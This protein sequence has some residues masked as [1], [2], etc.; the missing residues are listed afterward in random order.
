MN[1][2]EDIV[3][4]WDNSAEGYNTYIQG[5]LNN[6]KEREWVNLILSERGNKKLNIL[7]IGTGP[8]F[9][10]LILSKKGHKVTGIDCS[11]EMIEI[12]KKNCESTECDFYVMDSHKLDFKEDSFDMIISRNVTWTLYNPQEAYTEW[13]RVL[14][15]NGKLIIFDANWYLSCY[16]ENLKKEVEISEENYKKKYGIPYE[17]CKKETPHEFYKSLPLSREIRPKWDK[18]CLA[19]LGYKNI[20]ISNDIIEKVYDEREMALYGCTPLFKIVATK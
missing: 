10:A 4:R 14:K 11:K 6:F 8:G 16:D 19:N 18:S 1:I 9:F 17:S 12:A 5:E 2:K 7:D 15:P 20:K 13:T 3:D